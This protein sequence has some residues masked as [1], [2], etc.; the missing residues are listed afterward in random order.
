MKITGKA[1]VGGGVLGALGK[2]AKGAGKL[3]WTVLVEL[4]HEA[5]VAQ[6][7][8]EKE[9]RRKWSS[10]PQTVV[11]A[12]RNFEAFVAANGDRPLS[13]CKEEIREQLNKVREDSYQEGGEAFRKGVLKELE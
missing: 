3:A 10:E 8:R 5:R 2:A 11:D 4:P 12:R 1:S 6:E 7:R 13:E 9:R